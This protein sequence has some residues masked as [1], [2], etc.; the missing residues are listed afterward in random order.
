MVRAAFL[1]PA[2]RTEGSGRW[3]GLLP[4]PKAAR[5]G[6]GTHIPARPGTK[7]DRGPTRHSQG[8]SELFHSLWLGLCSKPSH[9]W[10]GGPEALAFPRLASLLLLLLLL[11]REAGAGRAAP[12]SRS[13]LMGNRFPRCGR[14]LRAGRALRG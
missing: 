14:V 12:T 13:R 10:H 11:I 6:S 3:E 7:R 1:H 4:L 5:A 8:R 2:H 9:P